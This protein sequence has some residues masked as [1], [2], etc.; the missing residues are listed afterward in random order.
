MSFQ[1]RLKSVSL[2]FAYAFRLFRDASLTE[3]PNLA[4]ERPYFQM[5]LLHFF[6]QSVGYDSQSLCRLCQRCHWQW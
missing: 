3:H 2:I 1:E 5:V 4:V 6:Y